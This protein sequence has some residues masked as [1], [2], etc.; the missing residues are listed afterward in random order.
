M[1]H[2]RHFISGGGE[3]LFWCDGQQVLG[4]RFIEEA[5]QTRKPEGQAPAVFGIPKDIEDFGGLFARTIIV[6]RIERIQREQVI[7]PFARS[8]GF[9]VTDAI[10]S[11]ASAGTGQLRSRIIAGISVEPSVPDRALPS[12]SPTAIS[13]ASKPNLAMDW[14]WTRGLRALRFLGRSCFEGSSEALFFGLSSRG[15]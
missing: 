3:Y 6:V 13:T 9:L 8:E 14:R 12:L 4:T 10:L 1:L 5:V 2:Y 11:R 15:R 7:P